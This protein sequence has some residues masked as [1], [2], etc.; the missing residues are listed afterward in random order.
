MRAPSTGRPSPVERR[1]CREEARRLL[2]AAGT[3]GALHLPAHRLAEVMVH[4]ATPSFVEQRF[5]VVPRVSRNV[6]VQRGERARE[7]DVLAEWPGRV[8]IVE[9]KS[10]LARSH[11]QKL[12]EDRDELR[13]VLRVASDTEA[14]FAVGALS[15][16][17]EARRLAQ[18]RGLLFID[19][20]LR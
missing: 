10:H 20:L 1:A 12:V 11:V 4:R 19:P 13:W 2:L 7:L 5:G 15:W 9:V 6:I 18:E 17:A 14:L 8:L 16:N 3:N